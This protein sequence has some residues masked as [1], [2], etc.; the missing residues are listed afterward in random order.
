[1]KGDKDRFDVTDQHVQVYSDGTEVPHLEIAVYRNGVYRGYIELHTH[2]VSD[3]SI[4]VGVTSRL[5][6]K[7]FPGATHP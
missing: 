7:K 6:T 3:D 1:M 2:K 4:S 5:E